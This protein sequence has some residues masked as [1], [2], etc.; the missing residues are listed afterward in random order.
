[1]PSREGV[2]MFRVSRLVVAVAACVSLFAVAA[3]ANAQTTYHLHNE[4]S[5]TAGLKQLKTAGPDV[6]SVPLQTANLKSTATG[7]KLVEDFDTQAGVPGVAGVI[8][9]GSTITFQVWMKKTANVGT[10]F[11]RAKLLL[12]SAA[13]TSLC[14]ATGTSALTTTLTKFT[15]SCNTTANVTL[16]PASR[17]FVWAGANMTAGSTTTNFAAE[18]D[19]EGT[20]NG[21]FNSQVAIPNPVP[22]PAISQLSPSIGGVGQSITV[23][24]SNFGATQGT[25]TLKFFSNRTAVP[26]AWTATSITAPVPSGSTT[27]NLTVTVAGQASTSLFTFQGAPNISSL[28]PTSGPIGQSITVTGTNFGATQGTSTVTFNGTLAVP[29]TWSNLS[30]AVPVPAGTTTGNV[31]VRTGTVNS[32]NRLFTVLPT[33][34]ISDLSTTSG[35]P[36]TVVAVT[37][38]N[39]GATKGTSTVRL[40][41]ILAA[42]TGPWNATSF[43]AVVPAGA[44]SGNVV[45]TVSNVASNGVPFTVPVLQA[46]SISP[47]SLSLPVHSLQ[48]F[49]ATA[50]YSDGSSQ[51]LTSGFTW[52]SRDTAVAAVNASGILQTLDEGPTTVQATVGA[53]VGSITLAVDGPSFVTAGTLN[54]ARISHTSTLL[55]DGTVLVAGGGAVN[56]V[57]TSAELYDPSA[58]AFVNTGSLVTPRFL[59]SATRLQSGKVLLAGGKTPMFGDYFLPTTSAEIYDP[60]TGLFTATGSLH[61]ARAGHTATLLANGKVLIFGGEVGGEVSHAIQ[62]YDPATG[63]FSET[64]LTEDLRDQSATRLDDGRVLIAGGGLGLSGNA[65]IAAAE[66]YEVAGG[67]LTATGSLAFA[68][69]DHSATLLTDGTVLIAGGY[70]S[71]TFRSSAELYS[72]LSTT[73]TS[74]GGLVTARAEH[75]AN[76]LDDGSVL[77][78]AGTLD[79]TINSTATAERYDPVTQ[80]F[81]GAGSLTVARVGHTAT[82]LNDG[83]VV[84]VG[85]M[86]DAAQLLSAAEVYGPPMPPPLS[87]LL[88]PGAL[89]LHPG[90]TRQFVAIDDLGH[91]RYDATWVVSHTALA[92]IGAFSSPTFAA[93]GYGQVTVTASIGMVT[94]QATVTIAPRSLHVTPGI[95]TMLLSETRAFSVVDDRGLPVAQAMWEISDPALATASMSGALNVTALAVG[96]V[97]LAASVEGVTADPAQITIV[98]GLSLGAG[99]TRWSVP[100][101]GGLLPK[102]VF[103]SGNSYGPALFA[104]SGDTA[105]TAIRGLTSDGQQLWQVQLPGPATGHSVRN[106]D[107]G[108]IVTLHNTCD[109]ANPMRLVSIDGAGQVLWEAVGASTCTSTAPQMAVRHDGA[110]IV[111]A[112]GNTSG[113]PELMV[114]DGATGTILATPAIPTSSF[115]QQSGETLQ[116]YSRIGPPVID[117]ASNGYVLY[118]VRQVAYPPEVTTTALWLMKIAPNFTTTITQVTTTDTN[119]NLLPGRI[120]PDGHGGVVV[121]WTFSPAQPPGDPSPLRAAHVAAGGGVAEFLLPIQPAE[122]LIGPDG[123]AVNPLLALGENDTAFV[124]YGTGVAAFNSLSGGTLWNHSAAGTVQLVIADATNGV[125]AKIFDGSGD[126][127]VVRFDAAGATAGLLTGRGI[128]YVAGNVWFGVASADAAVV[129]TGVQVTETSTGY[130]TPDQQ[131]TSSGAGSYNIIPAPALPQLESSVLRIKDI[132]VSIKD[133]LTNEANPKSCSGWLT[134]PHLDQGRRWDTFLDAMISGQRYLRGTITLNGKPHK[135]TVAMVNGPNPDKTFSLPETYLIGV[136]NIGAYFNPNEKM[137]PYKSATARANADTLIHELAH[138]VMGIDWMRP[139]GTNMKDA[140]HPE[141]FQ[142]TMLHDGQGTGAGQQL[143]QEMV[144]RW[145]SAIINTFDGTTQLQP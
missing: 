55:L 29:T 116:G 52:S 61:G 136:N 105:Q 44:S 97:T 134:N 40:N 56:E 59:H 1:M 20:L 143:N 73:F 37:G 144:V 23:T 115:E 21:N 94:A 117:G 111:S 82:T 133:K 42:T 108:L 58:R 65:A 70:S 87:L 90:D 81:L 50:H 60:A 17:Y 128:D 15:I 45:V 121:T 104:I 130:S 69:R 145:C 4:A 107:D 41:G 137:P 12:N 80:S 14:V 85:G 106:G 11:P 109:N 110:V 103:T 77:V 124:S 122:V 71:N 28:S 126:E 24:G 47:G 13:G 98:G 3:P 89:T 100:A 68:T 43:T 26:T 84:I 18:L 88:V 74:V 141:L 76:R 36:G 2:F 113:F 27:G 140:I 10:L 6:A 78:V 33:P 34:N 39:F 31:V 57:L 66:L 129:Y 46:I 79:G 83:T 93:I 72:P 119:T 123:L 22:P 102:Q 32:N 63:T 99:S 67:T 132:L 16:V 120:L 35:L 101:L 114:I 54:T 75:T 91:Q 25:S 118:E 9:S 131:G 8:P 51:P 92:S 38:T 112:P 95:A 7:E 86:S 64:G 53:V 62:T 125:Y 139:F 138:H 19:V 5:T 135:Q 30:I 127:T 142:I 49:K 96:Q 48:R